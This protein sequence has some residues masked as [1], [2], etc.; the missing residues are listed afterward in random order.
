[1]LLLQSGAS[2]PRKTGGT[3]AFAHVAGSQILRCVCCRR[4]IALLV[5][6]AAIR[7]L[8]RQPLRETVAQLLIASVLAAI[9]ALVTEAVPG[10]IGWWRWDVFWRAI[11][12]AMFV[13]SAAAAG[14]FLIAAAHS[15]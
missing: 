6:V 8:R 1:L 11:A 14:S 2:G 15:H 5:A 10:M 13:V 7:S 12:A 3:A 9:I 4:T